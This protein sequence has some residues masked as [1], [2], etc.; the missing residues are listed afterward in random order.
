MPVTHQAF[1]TLT[2]SETE[3]GKVF[4]LLR[5]TARQRALMTG[6]LETGRRRAVPGTA[7]RESG[8]PVQEEDFH[9]RGWLFVSCLAGSRKA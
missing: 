6:Q 7:T 4:V 2:G 8:R 5:Y 3:P 9:D 1:Q